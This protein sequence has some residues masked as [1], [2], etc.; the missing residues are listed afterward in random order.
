MLKKYI[1]IQ[2]NKTKQ[3]H[4]YSVMGDTDRKYELL[5]WYYSFSLFLATIFTDT[6]RPP[7]PPP[8]PPPPISD[9][10]HDGDDNLTSLSLLF[11]SP[12]SHHAV[13]WT[14]HLR[15]SSLQ[16]LTLWPLHTH[17]HTLVLGDRSRKCV[18]YNWHLLCYRLFYLGFMKWFGSYNI[19]G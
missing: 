15:M 18:I 7:P 8:P 13:L 2:K 10:P 16:P 12:I 9:N 1:K 11:S 3:K 14:R 4:N 19:S 5:L 6:P 17:A